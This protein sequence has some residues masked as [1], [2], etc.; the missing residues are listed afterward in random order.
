MDNFKECY[1]K[2]DKD[3]VKKIC[4]DTEIMILNSQVNE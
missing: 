4:K 1:E 2:D 3:I